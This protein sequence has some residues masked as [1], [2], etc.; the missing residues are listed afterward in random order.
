MKPIIGITPSMTTCEKT[1]TV[2]RAHV[3]AVVKAGGVPV[4]LPYNASSAVERI[5]KQ[6]DGLYL[7]GG[8]DIDPHYF[9]EEP[10]VKLGRIDPLRDQFELDIFH[11]T[12]ALNK[13]ILGICR[14]SQLMNVALGGTM[15]Q[16]LYA[17]KGDTFIQHNQDR[18]LHYGSHFVEVKRPSLLYDIVQEKRIKVNSAHHQA[19]NVLGNQLRVAARSKDSVIEAIEG[20]THPFMLGVQWHPERMIKQKDRASYAIYVSFIQA[21]AKK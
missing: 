21:A 19:N 13:P 18:P 7:T 8:G 17:Q 15:Y 3:E 14:G 4:I 10:H 1:Y 2:H 20:I 9:H 5:V 6:I 16:D 12:D 11:A